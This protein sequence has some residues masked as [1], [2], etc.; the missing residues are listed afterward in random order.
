MKQFFQKSLA[1]I[2][3]LTGKLVA[4]IKTIKFDKRYVIIGVAALLA[5]GLIALVIYV[6][7]SAF[8]PESPSWTTSVAGGDNSGAVI[9][10]HPDM[11]DDSETTQD[12]SVASSYSTAPEESSKDANS[13]APS[14][15]AG[16]ST[17]PNYSPHKQPP[18]DTPLD[19]ITVTLYKNGAP[20]ELSKSKLNRVKTAL[21]KMFSE[22]SYMQIVTVGSSNTEAENA[23]KYDTCIEVAYNDRGDTLLIPATGKYKY[24]I[25]MYKNGE[26]QNGAG[27][28]QGDD[29]IT[30]VIN[31]L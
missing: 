1:K 22:T 7:V 5:A 6:F 13:N 31:S 24:F 28:A 21:K 14:V 10:K 12:G 26:Y 17:S 2:K 19:N 15:T 16:S 30:S 18:L 23:K 9:S 25:F 29:T 8:S 27:W 11:S 3:E 4:K 20:S